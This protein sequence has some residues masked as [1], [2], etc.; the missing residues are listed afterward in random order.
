MPKG[1]VKMAFY[2]NHNDRN[3]IDTLALLFGVSR[4]AMGIRLE[5]MRLLP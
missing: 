5:E 3:I 1:V 4:Q 2:R